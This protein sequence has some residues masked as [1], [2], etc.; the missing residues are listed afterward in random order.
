[1][2]NFSAVVSLV[3]LSGASC[4]LWSCNFG[5]G[6]RDVGSSLGNTDSALIDAPGRRLAAGRFRKITVDGSLDEGGK[7]IALEDNDD[8]TRLAVIPYPDGKTCYVDPAVDFDRLS[9]RLSVELPGL[10][11]V[12]VSSDESDRGEIRLVDFNC[13]QAFDSIENAR[14]PR[15]LFPSSEPRGVLSIDGSGTLTMIV[16]GE[17]DLVEI[18]RNVSVART[19]QSYI[20]VQKGG[21]LIAYD[22]K[23]DAVDEFGK[24]VS[25]FIPHQGLRISVALIDEEGLAVWNEDDGLT[26]ISDTACRPNFWG[27]D[28]L[29]YYDPCDERKLRIYMPRNRIPLEG[30]DFITLDGPKGVADLNARSLNWGASTQSTEL[31]FLLGGADDHEGQLVIAKIPTETEPDEDHLDLL[32]Y[33]L[34][35]GHSGFLGGE[36]LTGIDTGPGTLVR[37]QRDEDEHPVGLETLEDDVVKLFGASAYS[38]DGILANFDGTVGDLVQLR[39]EAK[40]E[41]KS[42]TLLRD[43]PNQGSVKEAETGRFA[44]VAD[45]P[46]GRVGTLYLSSQDNTSVKAVATDVWPTTAR[47]LEQPRGLA[48]L[49]GEPGQPVAQ[50]KVY[51]IDSGLTVSIHEKVNEYRSLPWPSPGILYA[52]PEGKD[53]GLWYA[54]AR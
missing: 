43:V 18:D 39:E 38:P 10:F 1:M 35:D 25:E 17:K 11:S 2:R 44:L 8:G 22:G 46:D 14:L 52:V 33:Q 19:S 49:S 13:E 26:R 47:F 4:G 31:S 37:I 3:A 23:L 45:S 6:L 54:K 42:T 50:L 32:L 16:P 12:Q 41:I 5:D 20:F 48:Y 21:K 36:I 29:A 51:L 40:D 28:T 9:S 24:G 34:G 53:Q 7:V 15:V 27:N 30:D